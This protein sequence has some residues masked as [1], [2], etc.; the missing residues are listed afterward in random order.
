MAILVGALPKL[1]VPLLMIHTCVLSAHLTHGIGINRCPT[2]R[3]CRPTLPNGTDQDRISLQVEKEGV[4]SVRLSAR[5]YEG[6]RKCAGGTSGRPEASKNKERL[7][8]RRA[9]ENPAMVLRSKLSS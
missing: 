3:R 5:Y 6:C 8:A 4:W 1:I 2:C 7:G 9:Q